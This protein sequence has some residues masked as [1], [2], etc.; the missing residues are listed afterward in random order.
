[1]KSRAIWASRKRPRW[2]MLHRVRLAMQAGTFWNKLEG[3]IEADETFIGGLARN[4]HKNKKAQDHWHGRAGSGKAV[5]MGLLD[6]KTKQ[7]RVMHV[8]ERSARHACKKQVQ[9]VRARR[10]LRLHGRMAG[11]HG[12]DRE[13]VHQVIDHAEAYVQRQRAHE[14]R[15]R[16][17]GRS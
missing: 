2:F 15:L 1:M 9:E 7:V 5:V 8:P 16:I 12:L 14:R 4:M 3:E 6:R 17:S 11:Y 13:Y 10:L